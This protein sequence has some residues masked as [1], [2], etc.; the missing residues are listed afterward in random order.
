MVTY[1]VAPGLGLNLCGILRLVGQYIVVV[2]QDATL[3]T[4]LG[5]DKRSE[6]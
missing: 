6:T 2:S 5:L 4:G 3:S 1:G